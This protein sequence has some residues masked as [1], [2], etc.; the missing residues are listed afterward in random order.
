MD[1]PTTETTR[2]AIGKPLQMRKQHQRSTDTIL[3]RKTNKDPYSRFGRTSVVYA[4]SLTSLLHLL[5]FLLRNAKMQ[6][7][8]VVV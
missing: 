5:R 6:F 3:C 1:I 4:F 2:T 8:L 7:A